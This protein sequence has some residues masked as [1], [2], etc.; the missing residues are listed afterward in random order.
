MLLMT[1]GWAAK[2]GP[3]AAQCL[4]GG[5]GLVLVTLAC[6]R[7]GLTPASAGYAYLTVIVLQ[8]LMGSFV[9]SLV[10]SVVAVLCLRY[11][12]APPLLGLDIESPVGALEIATF[13]M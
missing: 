8:A 9:V 12:L 1:H 10:L 7:L 4:L 6:F 5:V 3:I 11:W 2:F 13:L